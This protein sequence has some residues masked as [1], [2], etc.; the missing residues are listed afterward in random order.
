[1]SDHGIAF[2]SQARVSDIVEAAT[3]RLDGAI[4]REARLFADASP[5]ARGPA[6][7]SHGLLRIL[8]SGEYNDIMSGVG[9]TALPAARLAL[10]GFLVDAFVLHALDRGFRYADD[11]TG[12]WAIIRQLEVW[13][14]VLA[15]GNMDR[16]Q[17]R[18][19]IQ[20]ALAEEFNR[21]LS[22]A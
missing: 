4:E 8:E 14:G 21:G 20:L 6:E 15:R 5:I 13:A 7:L 22:R 9:R 18:I 12:L 16:R 17:L 11:R 1:M 3:L 2:Q 10:H 19:K